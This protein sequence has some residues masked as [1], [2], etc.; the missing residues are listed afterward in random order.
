MNDTL[1]EEEWGLEKLLGDFFAIIWMSQKVR[2]R[3]LWIIPIAKSSFSLSQVESFIKNLSLNVLFLRQ[4]A[5]DRNVLFLLLFWRVFPT[6]C[7][8]CIPTLW[9]SSRHK[10]KLR[11]VFYDQSPQHNMQY[12]VGFMWIKNLTKYLKAQ[13]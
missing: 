6:F 13:W 7:T 8:M 5:F 9:R 10:G 11:R 12:R 3:H 1:E 4:W 2:W